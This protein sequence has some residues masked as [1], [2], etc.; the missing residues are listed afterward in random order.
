M[1]SLER[2]EPTPPVIDAIKALSTWVLVSSEHSH[3]ATGLGGETEVIQ[4]CRHVRVL[5][6]TRQQG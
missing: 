1:D 4:L 5:A 6:A 2:L 3:D